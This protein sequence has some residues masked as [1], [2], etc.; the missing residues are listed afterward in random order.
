MTINSNEMIAAWAAQQTE[1]EA[2]MLNL[3]IGAVLF[4]LGQEAVTITQDD[5]LRMLAQYS[6]EHGHTDDRAGWSVSLHKRNDAKIQQ[7]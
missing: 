7:K 4:K 3:A 5:I 1:R 2:A 6:V